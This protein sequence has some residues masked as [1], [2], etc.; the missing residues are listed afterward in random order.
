[1]AAAVAL[2]VP[3]GL[4]APAA[5]DSGSRYWSSWDA[6]WE[7]WEVPEDGPRTEVPDD[8][9]TVGL[10]YSLVPRSATE[11]RQ[12]RALP[13]FDSSCRDAV[14][15]EGVKRVA[16]VV[17]YGRGEEAP[18][19]RPDHLPQVETTCATVPVDFT[20]EQTLQSVL[21]VEDT[22]QGICAVNGHPSEGCSANRVEDAD[23]AV[24]TASE[25]PVEAVVL[26]PEEASHT[27]EVPEPASPTVPEDEG[28][29]PAV[30]GT[31]PESTEEGTGEDTAP[32]EDGVPSP[33]ESQG[34]ADD[35]AD[36]TDE[37]APGIPEEAAEVRAAGGL[38][39]WYVTLAVLA[40]LGVGL[41]LVLRPLPAARGGGSGG[42]R[43]TL[44]RR[45]QERR[46]A[47]SRTRD[48]HDRNGRGGRP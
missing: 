38:I 11:G 7:G 33:T 40:L 24:L 31:G 18:V 35:G 44:S 21:D 20:T 26:S 46:R 25:E 28:D 48:D 12:P 34:G 29:D 1:M 8:G 13:D 10:R 3:A 4:A 16:V 30:T 2:V 14:W 23:P 43:S 37:A 39:P 32:E 47:A 41:W 36:D 27:P 22:G 9:S 45:L 6:G 15:Y 17:D 19:A 5:A 42:L